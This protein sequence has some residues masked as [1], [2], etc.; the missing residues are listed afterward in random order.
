MTSINISLPETLRN[1]VEKRVADGGFSTASEYL[2]DL[3]RSDRER[4]RKLDEMRR[5]IQAG[6]EQA[7]R[8][9]LVPLDVDAIKAEGRK[10]LQ[11]SQRKVANA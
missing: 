9:E 4:A 10:L 7:N 5:E 2:R 6:V 8:G 11:R 1:F 3:I